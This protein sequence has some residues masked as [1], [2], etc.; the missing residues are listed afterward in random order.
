[1]EQTLPPITN[2]EYEFY[3]KNKLIE[4]FNEDTNNNFLDPLQNE[5]GED[6]E[7]ALHFHEYLFLLGLIAKM[8]MPTSKDDSLP[9]KLQEFYVAKLGFEAV[10][11]SKQKDLT[12]EEV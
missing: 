2:G 5:K 10:N 1:M 8:S 3:E 4:A 9:S 12:Y 6:M 7:P 11:I